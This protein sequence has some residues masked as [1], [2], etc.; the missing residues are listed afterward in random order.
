VGYALLAALAILPAKAGAQQVTLPL[1]KYEALRAR[2]NPGQETPT[3]PP[4]PY[5]LELAEYAVKVGP[6]SAR[7][8]QTLRLTLYDDKW[9][10]VP[11][12]EAG[13][14]IAAD[15]KGG[16]GRVEVSDKG[17][18]MHVRGP[19]RR[20]VRL[21]SAVPVSRDDKATRPTWRFGLRFPAAAVVRGHIE[22]A[23]A[24]E[25]V[26]P[27]GSGLVLAGP[28]GTGWTFV[29]LPGTEVRWTLSGRATVP[30]RATLPLRF[31]ATSATASTLFRT[32][33]QV[34]GWIEVRVAQG[35]LQT[36][37]VPVPAGLE[38]TD[39]HG[40][41]AGWKV[42]A[43]TLI[44]TPLAPVEDSLAVEMS[45][46]G[47]PKDRF[48]TPLLI[49]EGSART[50]LLAKAALKGDGILSLIDSGAARTPEERETAH[51]PDSIKTADGRLF[52][53]TDAAR[54]PSWEAARAER[55]E[56]LA[57]QVD[58][59]LVD[60]ALGEAGKASYQIWA[61]IRNRGAQQLTLTLPPGFELAVAHRDGVAVVPGKTGGSLAVPML[62]QEA[63]QVVH[64]EGVI[65]L[66]LP[67]GDG[68]LSV[69]LPALSAPVAK[70]EVRLILPG[71]RSYELAEK[72]RA[73]QVGAPPG[74][75]ARKAVSG[76]GAQAN[77]QI[78]SGQVSSTQASALALFNIPPG[79]AALQASWSAL[80]AAPPPLAVR[81]SK[82][83]E[84][85]EW[86]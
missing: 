79:F 18:E 13:S 34:L 10:T 55:T 32:R 65:P 58:R 80:S 72:A 71:G 44:V 15:F 38:V 51:L 81:V 12:G 62:T 2:A 50:I 86:F 53:V 68:A 52:A 43:G 46:T 1:D 45:L 20:E 49:P 73:G 67:K 75:A 74:T 61:E 54:P 30:R 37:R 77:A 41:V 60:V 69:P 57:A 33:F 78:M 14:F 66:D 59:L 3:V 11:L 4:A 17:L 76:L 39:V 85:R 42:E 26:D 27:E 19:G 82:E 6:E 70:V 8:V 36:L 83:K 28:P 5:A 35:R 31:E 84:K 23:A 29:A 40:P 9:Q 24:V 7:V 22:A 56:V 48:A 16:E 25:E 47:E 63:A 64:L 21:E